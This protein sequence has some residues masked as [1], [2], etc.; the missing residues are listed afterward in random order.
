MHKN[1]VKRGLVPKAED[2]KWSSYRHYLTAV[3]GVVQ[4]ESHWTAENRERLG[5]LPS[6]E[7]PT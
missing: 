7:R 5:I 4:I 2:W 1:P 3:K 6:L